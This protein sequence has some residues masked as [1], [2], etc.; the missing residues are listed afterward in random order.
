VPDAGDVLIGDSFG[1]DGMI[2]DLPV[3]PLRVAGAVLDPEDKPL[4]GCT[5]AAGP[6]AHG[7]GTAQTGT[8]G[9]FLMPLPTSETVRALRIRCEGFVPAERTL[10]GGLSGDVLLPPVLMTTAAVSVEVPVAGSTVSSPNGDISLEVQPGAFATNVTVTLARILLGDP[11]R[12]DLRL[13]APLPEAPGVPVSGLAAVVLDAGGAQPFGPLTARVKLSV[14]LPE[15]TNVPVGRFDPDAG[16]WVDMG[17]GWIEADGRLAFETDHFST[18]AATLPAAPDPAVRGPE[19]SA[20]NRSRSPFVDGDPR[21][22]PRSGALQVGFDVPSLV[23]HNGP[24]GLTFFFD[25]RTLSGEFEVPVGLPDA[26]SGE[27][28]AL[29]IDSPRGSARM[30]VTAETPTVPDAIPV[31]AANLGAAGKMAGADAEADDGTQPAKTTAAVDVEIR[32]SRPAAASLLESASGSFTKPTAGAVLAGGDGKPIATPAPV[33]RSRTE[34]T[35]AVVDNRIDGPFGPGWQLQGLTRLVQPWCRKDR[36][37]LVG[38]RDLPAR[39]Y[40]PVQEPFLKDHR[41]ELAAAGVADADM[42]DTRVARSNGV[43]YTLFRGKHE[44]WSRNPETGVLAKAAGIGTGSGSQPDWATAETI[45]A[46]RGG[47]VLVAS[48]LG[49]HRVAPDGSSAVVIGGGDETNC[50]GPTEGGVATSTALC[51]QSPMTLAQDPTSDRTVFSM[52]GGDLWESKEGV[53]HKMRLKEGSPHWFHVAFD[54]KGQL[55]Y[56]SD[57]GSCIYRHV[58]GLQDPTVMPKCRVGGA[59]Q[60]G[61]AAIATIGHPTTLATDD[62]DRLLF[63]DTGTGSGDAGGRVRRISADGEVESITRP[64]TTTLPGLQGVGGPLQEASLG[65]VD[66]LAPGEGSALLAGGTGLAGFVEGEKPPADALLSYGGGDGS[67]LTAQKDGTWLRVLDDGTME[68]YDTRGLLQSRGRAGQPPLVFRYAGDWEAPVD[69]EVCDTPLTPPRLERIEFNGEALFLFEYSG[70]GGRLSKVRDAT[71]RD[72]VWSS[73]TGAGTTFQVTLPGEVRVDFRHDEQ[74]LLVERTL[75]LPGQHQGKWTYEYDGQ[76]LLSVMS[77]IRGGRLIVAADGQ[78][79][80]APA[81]FSA[82]RI[83]SDVRAREAVGVIPLPGG[84]EVSVAVTRR[85][86]RVGGPGDRTN[87]WDQDAW[88]RPTRRVAGDGG[89]LSMTYDEAGRLAQLVNEDTHETW[90]YRWGRPED[91]PGYR[92]IVD[93][94]LLERI[95]PGQHST[96]FNWDD[97][98]RVVQR[99]DPDGGSTNFLW[100]TI[101]TAMG[102]LRSMTDAAN[103]VHLY[104]YD[105]AGNTSEVFQGRADRTAGWAWHMERDATGRVTRLE[106]PLTG[107]VES[108]WDARGGLLSQRRLSADGL[109]VLD[110]W[111]FTRAT[112]AAWESMGEPV[113]VSAVLVAEDGE[114]RTWAET[115]DENGRRAQRVDPAAG[116]ERYGYD[117]AGRIT[118]IDWPDDSRQTVEWDDAGR[119]WHR[120]FSGPA[121]GAGTTL[122][123]DAQGRVGKTVG[124][125]TREQVTYAVGQGLDTLSVAPNGTTGEG[126]AFTLHRTRVDDVFDQVL[127]M[128]GVGSMRIRRAFDDTVEEVVGLMQD[129]GGGYV[130]LA[131]VGRDDARRVIAIDRA[132]GV[133]T[134][135]GYDD[136]GRPTWQEEKATAGT[137]RIEW[138]YGEGPRPTGVSLGGVERTYGWDGAGRLT[139]CSDTGETATWDKG[140]A[141]ASSTGGAFTRDAGGRLTDD[142]TATLE[143]DALGRVTKRTPKVGGAGVLEVRYGAGGLPAQALVDGAEVARYHYDELGRRVERITAEGA[144]HYGYLP[145]TN[146]PFRISEP[147]GREWMLVDVEGPLGFGAAVA[148]DGSQVF[149]HYDPYQRVIGWSDQA[150]TFVPADEECFGLP[151]TTPATGGP[152]LGFHGV[153][154]DPE[155]GLYAIG[156]RLYDPRTGEFLQPEPEG[157]SPLAGSYTYA[158]GDPVLRADPNG[159]FLLWALAGGL[160]IGAGILYEMRELATGNNAQQVREANEATQRAVDI[161]KQEDD[162]TDVATDKENRFRRLSVQGGEVAVKGVA[163][164]IKGVTN[165]AQSAGDAVDAARETLQN[166]VED[167]VQKSQQTTPAPQGGTPP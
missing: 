49:V 110:A 142:G 151:R 162:A 70:S 39:V 33:A 19:L 109:Q 46:A 4:A 117:L 40:G 15:G 165:P 17:T 31:V 36:I 3:A 75:E 57:T 5:I 119:P 96:R 167:Q 125:A 146:R 66:S 90:T 105:N 159:R 29:R 11:L 80:V 93:D 135:R 91:L 77:P 152:Q 154:F 99:I 107:V 22:D 98:G 94:R 127:E 64:W 103:L 76:R 81:A 148:K 82:A 60:D 161:R 124:G 166:I 141:R 156:P 84:G 130:S 126:V 155:T 43:S 6:D 136:L 160:A 35:T 140:S 24:V 120:T 65:G 106:D 41:A 89:V 97:A 12:D 69:Q 2:G 44:V 134:T 28:L 56:S 92:R 30:A 102:L 50:T 74:G 51:G 59:L 47:G 113:P 13:P 34:H 72:T 21:V 115:W 78:V 20:L 112:T 42:K 55:Y 62:Q 163:E 26:T 79:M 149:V 145:D 144:W 121:A 38:E 61:P 88:G 138:R 158:G 16:I 123:F 8:G 25:S 86:L 32:A 83:A 101:G 7:D 73:S 48:T 95:D 129:M 150:G 118:A 111:T 132:N 143:F 153:P 52:P 100:E 1:D 10:A 37:L 54:T 108:T 23:R 122:E 164:S 18:F 128:L 139:A 27:S 68:T 58:D 85:G 137:F 114:G 71:G 104:T 157:F 131:K 53:L 45:T 133:Q 87:R 147:S 63:Y 14:T 67:V 116:F 9:R